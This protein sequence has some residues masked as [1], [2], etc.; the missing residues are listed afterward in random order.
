MKEKDKLLWNIREKIQAFFP[1]DDSRFDRDY[2]WEQCKLARNIFIEKMYQEDKRNTDVFFSRIFLDVLQ[3]DDTEYVFNE[4]YR[5]NDPRESL[6]IPNPNI[7]S[8][9]PEL[10]RSKIPALINLDGNIRYLGPKDRS[11]EFYRASTE[12]FFRRSGRDFTENNICYL[13]F[14]DRIF[15]S[16]QPMKLVDGEE[17][18]ID[19]VE[20]W[21]LLEDPESNSNWDA[22]KDSLVPKK[23]QMLLEDMVAENILKYA[24]GGILSRTNDATDKEENPRN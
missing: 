19:T 20:M 7:E 6:V 16:R 17:I 13:A 11:I 15:Y 21:A 24:R 14:G 9:L 12:G 22:D 23:Y 3:H 4:N 1:V 5:Y 2:I 8:D 18:P 10:F